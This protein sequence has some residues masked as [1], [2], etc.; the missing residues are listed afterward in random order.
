MEFPKR[1]LLIQENLVCQGP[2]V[3][4]SN[5]I[6]CMSFLNRAELEDKSKCRCEEVKAAL[7]FRVCKLLPLSVRCRSA[8]LNEVSQ[9]RNPK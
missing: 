7:L 5:L 4:E 9:T 1:I 6:Q 2:E 8:S 3:S